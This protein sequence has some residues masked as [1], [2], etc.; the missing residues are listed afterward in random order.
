MGGRNERA[1][2]TYLALNVDQPVSTD[3]IVDALWGEAPPPTAREMVR[4]YVA[5]ARTRLGEVLQRRS[6]GYVLAVSPEAVDAYLFERQVEEGLREG[7]DGDHEASAR[8]LHR[9]LDL[10][11]GPPLQELELPGAGDEGRRLEEL[12]LSAVE[13]WARAALSLGHATG[14]IPELEAVVRQYPY[15]ERLRADLMLALYRAGRQTDALEQ[16]REA[17]RLLVEEIGVEPGRELQE[18]H[19][20]ILRQDPALDLSL[21]LPTPVAPRS[22]EDPPLR[23]AARLDRRL[24]KVVASVCVLIGAAALTFLVL[25]LEGQVSTP[26]LHRRS[27]GVLDPVTGTVVQTRTLGGDPGSLAVGADTAWVGDGARDA[28]ITMSPAT[29]RVRSSAKLVDFP[30]QLATDGT[31]LWVGNGFDGTLTRIEPSGRAIAPFRPEARSLGR[32]AL[33][34]GAGALWVGSQD[35]ALSEVQPTDD[36][37]IT[38]VRDIGKPNALAVGGGAVWIAEATSDAVLR[39]GL[40]PRRVHRLIP[41]GGLPNALAIADGSVWVATPG[42]ALLWRIDE[43]TGAVTA[44]IDVGPGFSLVTA[45]HGQVW[46]ASLAGSAERVDPAKNMV[47]RT[48]DLAGPVGGLTAGGGH[49]WISLR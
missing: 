18:L 10:W 15:R 44:S 1:L 29:M 41:I 37:T 5:R 6:G 11:R 40:T 24:F 23:E 32:L 31:R 3:G 49:V 26:S 42:Q 7:R 33:A 46:V 19:G 25:S 30:Y 45:S 14:L 43:L 35:G 4:T 8:T 27:V 48:I 38:V 36:R 21:P 9:A 22:R 16:Y 47:V 13:G 28:V 17:R 20:A 12:R 34:Y 2:I 39:V